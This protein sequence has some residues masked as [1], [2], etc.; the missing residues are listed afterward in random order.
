[1]N[2][3]FKSKLRKLEIKKPR[4]DNNDSKIYYLNENFCKKPEIRAYERIQYNISTH[5]FFYKH[6]ELGDGTVELSLTNLTTK[7]QPIQ[8]NTPEGTRIVH[9]VP[10]NSFEQDGKIIN[11]Y[12][13][14]GICRI[15]LSKT[16]FNQ[17]FV[18]NITDNV[19]IKYFG[20]LKQFDNVQNFISKHEFKQNWIYEERLQADVI[21][22]LDS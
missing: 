18:Y 11:Q 12:L 4:P 21:F 8:L 13:V 7:D 16:A 9:V 5:P 14:D 3:F 15:T 22:L 6:K 10:V 20:S 17:Y 1:M 19:K 2:P